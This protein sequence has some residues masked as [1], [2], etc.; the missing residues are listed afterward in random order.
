MEMEVDDSPELY[1]IQTEKPYTPTPDYSD[2][3]DFASTG[4]AIVI[5][6][7]NNT[8]SDNLHFLVST[9]VES[10]SCFTHVDECADVYDICS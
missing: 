2:Y 6:N 9:I 4:T 5:D 1:P 3:K 8:I 10:I 7:G